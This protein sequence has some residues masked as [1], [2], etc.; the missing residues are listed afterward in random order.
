M[1]INPQKDKDLDQEGEEIAGGTNL[2]D[3]E[4]KRVAAAGGN[5]KADVRLKNA[6]ID[7]IS[8]GRVGP[9]DAELRRR[10]NR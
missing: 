7:K 10:V 3:E 1:A 6:D 5:F 4:L 2:T 8:G 9:S